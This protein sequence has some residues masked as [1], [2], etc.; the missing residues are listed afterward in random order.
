METLT[1]NPTYAEPFNLEDN[2]LSEVRKMF[3]SLFKQNNDANEDFIIL[4]EKYDQLPAKC[5]DIFAHI[6]NI[7]EL[8]LNRIT[9]VY[10]GDVMP[11]RSLSKID[12]ALRNEDNYYITLGLLASESYGKNY[13]W[14]FT[15]INNEEN[16]IQTNLTDAYFH[17]LSHSVYHRGQIAYILKQNGIAL[18]ETA[19]SIL[20]K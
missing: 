5:L 6:I 15:Y 14:S 13:N 17:I 7:H 20:K 9:N 19:F 2:D 8:W 11:W 16:P 3:S 12:F 4:F 18:P 1:L 10:D